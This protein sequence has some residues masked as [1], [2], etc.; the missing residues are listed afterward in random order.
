[1]L[2]HLVRHRP[3]LWLLVQRE[4]RSRY[5]GSTL[6]VVWN[7][8]HPIV[9]VALY[10]VVFSRI[11]GEKLGGGG[12]Y[13]VHLCA[14]IV[15]WFFFS[16]VVARS[17]TALVDNAHFLKKMVLPEEILY[18]GVFVNSFMTYMVSLL[19][20]GI[21][22]SL[23]GHPSGLGV[24]FAAPVLLALGALGL[25]LGMVLSVLH[26]LVRDIGQ[27]VQILLQ[28][29]FWSIPIVYVPSILPQ[30]VRD[31]IEYNPLRPYFSLI[32]KLMGSPDAQFN[33]DGYYL[34]VMLPLLALL[35]GLSFLRRNRSEILDQL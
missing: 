4:F 28:I 18:L 15:P 35:A 34:I 29:T 22:L 27:I 16:E 9:L 11:M 30:V 10:V 24:L 7:V 2:Q 33:N 6:G 17:T 12:H 20:L 31:I 19:A 32:Q 3:L 5:A 25:G 14:G 8:V 23:A 26:L 13:V 21:L 1:M